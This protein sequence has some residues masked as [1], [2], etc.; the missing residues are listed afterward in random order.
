[1][2]QNR[3]CFELYIPATRD[4]LREGF[5]INHKNTVLPIKRIAWWEAA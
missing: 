1:M 2:Q 4:K 3:K 5:I